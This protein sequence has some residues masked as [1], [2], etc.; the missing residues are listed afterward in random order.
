MP[1][2]FCADQKIWKL[3][4]LPRAF[5]CPLGCGVLSLWAYRRLLHAL[6]GPMSS[7][8]LFLGNAVVRTAI[9]EGQKYAGLFKGR[10][11]CLSLCLLLG[12]MR[13]VHGR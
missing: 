8:D 7:Y 10:M 3:A 12:D 13:T 2:L 11:A 9:F 4:S 6:S 5:G 1:W